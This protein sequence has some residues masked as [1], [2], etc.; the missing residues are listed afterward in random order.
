MRMRTVNEHFNLVLKFF[1]VFESLSSILFSITVGRRDLMKT[2][3]KK[4]VTNVF[5]REMFYKGRE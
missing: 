2:S 5:V 1:P 3:R 4:A